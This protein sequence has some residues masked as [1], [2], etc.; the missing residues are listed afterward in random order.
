MDSGTF[1]FGGVSPDLADQLN[2]L[3]EVAAATGIRLA[4]GRIDG[5]GTAIL[6]VDPETAFPVLCNASARFRRRR[7]R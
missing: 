3:P 6:G 4:F 7:G 2:Q 1:G 5:S